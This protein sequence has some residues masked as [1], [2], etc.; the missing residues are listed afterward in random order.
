M[1]FKDYKV[2][3]SDALLRHGIY[4][5]DQ[6]KNRAHCDYCNL[7]H[8]PHYP[9]KDGWLAYVP[10]LEAHLF[11]DG[12]LR[13]SIEKPELEDIEVPVTF[14][15]LVASKFLQL[16]R[17]AARRGKP[18]DLSLRSVANILR[19]K[20]CYYTGVELTRG[21]AR[22]PQ[23]TDLTVDRKDPTKGYVKGNVV[24]CCHLANQFKSTI[25]HELPSVVGR[26][27]MARIIHKM[28]EA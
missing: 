16:Q 14:D 21:D 13:D 12:T 22:K 6:Q 26:P 18:F 15:G 24:A 8:M 27:R 17:S 10:E 23:P 5:D 7:K 20:R 2:V 3:L 1:N 9:R 28:F 4:W 11:T 19:A 25:E